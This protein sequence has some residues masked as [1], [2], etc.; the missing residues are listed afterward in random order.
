M[1]I[2]SPWAGMCK[3]DFLHPGRSRSPHVRGER[4]PTDDARDGPQP[5]K[6]FRQVPEPIDNGRGLADVVPVRHGLLPD[7]A[8]AQVDRLTPLPFRAV[9]RGATASITESAEP[10]PALIGKTPIE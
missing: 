6:A 4:S 7:R 8:T 1:V 10:V 5:C 3:G 2:A 9:R